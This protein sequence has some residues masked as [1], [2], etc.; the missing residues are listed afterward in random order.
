M[1]I[2]VFPLEFEGKQRIG[3]K[4]LMYDSRFP[5]MMKRIP[6]SR[7][8]PA[9]KC[10]HIPYDPRSYTLLKNI[11]GKGHVF[12]DEA[13]AQSALK[14]TKRQHAE[15]SKGSLKY[16]QEYIRMQ[17]K[18][19]LQRYSPY[20]IK[21][22][23][24]F[25]LLL[26]EYYPDI[27]P[28]ELSKEQLMKFLLHG[29]AERHW[30]GST[31]NQAVNALKYYYEKV[32]GQERTYYEL[33]A[34]KRKQLP[35]VFSEEEIIRLFKSVKNLKHRAILMLIYS[36]GLRIGESVNLRV[37]DIHFDR[38][39]IF[40]VA[41]KGKKD[42]YSVLSDKVISLL[43]EYIKTYRPAY[44]LFEGQDGGQ[45]STRSIQHIFRKAVAKSKVNPF[46]TVHTLRHSFA[47]HL[48]ERGTDLRYIQELLGHNS[49]ETT[50]IYTH[51][52]KKAK[53]KLWSPL[54]FLE[55]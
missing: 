40:I 25:F 50:E 53:E 15:T 5:E 43:D 39:R 20:T 17:E 27:H 29:V 51:I 12:T 19:M 2:Q 49:S 30:S 54:D 3:I 14:G 48:L 37:G 38:K 9:E 11:F 13:S 36:G 46:S 6:G 16:Y 33:R 21:T 1:K 44:W 18:M 52:T 45:Y 10:W 23:K 4:P 31:Q 47:T 55:L 7:W 26:L 42:R 22:Y 34:K 24:C 8:T 41:G 28:E 35:N 32:L